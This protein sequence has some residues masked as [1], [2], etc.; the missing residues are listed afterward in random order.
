MQKSLFYEDV[1]EALKAVI[2]ALGGA[3]KVGP[4]LWP[5]KTMEAA[6][7]LL[8]ACLNIER[9]EHLTPE[10]MML[11]LTWGH[12]AGCH[13]GFEYMADAVG[14]EKP[15]AISREEKQAELMRDFN[16]QV[17]RLNHT[18][19][20]LTASGVAMPSTLKAVV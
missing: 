10:Q 1:N 4:R 8:L 11:L 19:S 12:V 6:Q 7:Q 15:R 3:K 9:K 2:S 17:E 14:Y 16:K 18:V 20:L 5:E 13:I